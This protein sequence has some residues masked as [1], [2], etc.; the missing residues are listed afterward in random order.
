[1]HELETIFLPHINQQESNPWYDELLPKWHMVEHLTCKGCSVIHGE[2]ERHGLCSCRVLA[3][4][5]GANR[6]AAS[7]AAA[8]R[9][10]PPRA[11]AGRSGLLCPPAPHGHFR[12]AAP[13]RWPLRALLFLDPGMSSLPN[14]RRMGGLALAACPVYYARPRRPGPPRAGRTAA[15]ACSSGLSLPRMPTRARPSRRSVR[16]RLAL[17]PLGA[18]PRRSRKTP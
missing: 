2:P 9:P 8:G 3:S 4:W 15:D 7:A 14:S 5:T 18:G 12:A 1:M 16:P 17:T 11:A 6:Q 13:C 10:P